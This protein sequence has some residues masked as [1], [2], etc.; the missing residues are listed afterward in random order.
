M[1]RTIM[2][3]GRIVS[4]TTNRLL[5]LMEVRFLQ[6]HT[7]SNV[8][9]PKGWILKTQ[10]KPIPLELPTKEEMEVMFVESCL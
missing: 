3:H 9:V 4:K 2:K 8:G 5:L 1:L 10:M 7:Y 6:E